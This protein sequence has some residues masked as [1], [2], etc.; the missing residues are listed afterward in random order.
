MAAGSLVQLLII[1]LDLENHPRCRFDYIEISE[2]IDRKNSQRYCSSP[3]ANVIPTKSNTVTVRFRSDFTNSGRGFHLKYETRESIP[4]AGRIKLCPSNESDIDPFASAP[5]A[6]IDPRLIEHFSPS[7]VVTTLLHRLWP[8]NRFLILRFLSVCENTVRG[9]SG[10]IES[11]NFPEKY[12]HNMNCSWIIAAP[13]GNRINITFSHF[14]LEGASGNNTCLYDYLEVKEGED[15]V[16]NTQIAKLCDSETL[17]AKIHST[18]NQVFLK[19]VT[20]SVLAYNGFRLEWVIDGCGGH[21]TKPSDAFT[22]PGYPFTYP[23][24]VHCE[25]LIEVDY[26]HSIELTIHDVSILQTET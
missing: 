4:L 13:I 24:N 8:G 12:E 10:V 20:D 26:M 7:R 18:Q 25:W 6:H 21:L 16:P 19:F 2:G 22:S 11:P 9:F 14:D 17:P 23:T 5:G 1:D 3:Y 15:G